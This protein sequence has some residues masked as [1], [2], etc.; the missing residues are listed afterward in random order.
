MHAS[1][2]S[3]TGPLRIPVLNLDPGNMKHCSEVTLLKHRSH[4]FHVYLRTTIELVWFLDGRVYLDVE[5]ILV[6][7]LLNPLSYVIW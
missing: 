2:G 7:S 6:D 5:E 1:F 4:S 3:C